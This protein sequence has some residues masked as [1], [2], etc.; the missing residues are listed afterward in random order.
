MFAAG[1]TAC[2]T[3]TFAEAQAI[4]EGAGTRLCTAD[5]F[6]VGGQACLRGT[7]CGHDNRYVWTSTAGVLPGAALAA[8]NEGSA[9]I[10]SI[11]TTTT[12]EPATAAT[13]AAANPNESDV[14]GSGSAS[15]G[16]DSGSDGGVIAVVIIGI[17]CIIGALGTIMYVRQQRETTKQLGAGSQLESVNYRHNSNP[18]AGPDRNESY[19]AA[20]AGPDAASSRPLSVC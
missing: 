9:D 14:S 13:T 4:C 19:A 3:G 5:E 6:L 8:N 7:G 17:L 11:A 16:D 15:D 1:F 12:D 10:N 18:N 2:E 20:N